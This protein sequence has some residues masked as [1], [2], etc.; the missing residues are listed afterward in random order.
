MLLRSR[1][2]RRGG[3]PRVLAA[4]LWLVVRASVAAPA[5][6]VEWP[7]TYHDAASSSATSLD[8]GGDHLALDWVVRVTNSL[9]VI[10]GGFFFEGNVVRSLDDG[11]RITTLAGGN[12]V[13]SGSRVF[14]RDG[15]TLRGYQIGDASGNGWTLIWQTAAP[16]LYRLTA[17][18]NGVYGHPRTGALQKFN[19]A[20]GE[21]EWTT[22]KSYYVL[23]TP[24]VAEVELGGSPHEIA[25]VGNGITNYREF[26][27]HKRQYSI[28]AFNAA[29]GALVWRTWTGTKMFGLSVDP[30]LGLVFGGEWEGDCANVHACHTDTGTVKWSRMLQFQLN[31]PPTLGYADKSGVEHRAVFCI[32]ALDSIVYAFDASSGDPLWER[33]ISPPPDDNVNSTAYAVT[34]AAG[35]LYLNASKGEPG[36]GEG[37]L[38]TLDADAPGTVLDCRRDLTW[39][40]VLAAMATDGPRLYTFREITENVWGLARYCASSSVPLKA[41][42]AALPATIQADGQSASTITFTLP[43]EASAPDVEVT[44]STDLGAVDPATAMTDANGRATTRL[45]SHEAGIAF[46]VAR[47][48]AAEAAFVP[49]TIHAPA[50]PTGSIAGT[51]IYADG[52]PVKGATVYATQDGV[53]KGQAATGTDG[54]YTIAGLALATYDVQAEKRKGKSLLTSDAQRASI[55]T[56]G[57]TVHLDLA[58]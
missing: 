13:V 18:G 3:R 22:E 42:L 54:S 23:H 36:Q 34:Y 47:C 41:P 39:G 30:A 7:V 56:P 37:Y 48:Q 21:R 29:T 8:L 14:L 32:A 50:P 53:V 6:G 17:R 40:P 20:T 1:R 16:D 12:P 5:A 33:D 49:V 44:F 38:Y 35:R 4:L 2:S 43:A 27:E 15:S 10:A 46:V 57:Q 19:A 11:R 28:N 25:F 45:T 26:P 9:P 51:V 31:T 55:Q 58:F 24:A 52:R